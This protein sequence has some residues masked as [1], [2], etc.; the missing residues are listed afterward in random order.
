MCIESFTIHSHRNTTDNRFCYKLFLGQTGT[1]LFWETSHVLR[2]MQS[3]RHCPPTLD[4]LFQKRDLKK[5]NIVPMF[6]I[7]L[8]GNILTSYLLSEF[9]LLALY[10]AN[11]LRNSEDEKLS[12]KI[13]CNLEQ[14]GHGSVFGVRKNDSQDYQ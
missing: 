8:V 3:L 9:I 13:L 7:F 12:E 6:P 2:A 10:G 11:I 5:Q 4:R 14:T 1:L